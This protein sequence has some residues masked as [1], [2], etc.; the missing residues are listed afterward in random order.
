MLILSKPGSGS[1]EAMEVEHNPDH[2]QAGDIWG[3][4]RSLSASSA[5]F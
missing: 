5:I 1:F 2:S 3:S 4:D